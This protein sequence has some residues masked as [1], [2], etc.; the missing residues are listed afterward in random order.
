MITGCTDYFP[1]AARIAITPGSY[2]ARVYYR[3]LSTVSAN[4]LQGE[5]FYRVVLWPAPPSAVHVHKAGSGA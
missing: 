3:G 1:D 5:D 4:A 2:R